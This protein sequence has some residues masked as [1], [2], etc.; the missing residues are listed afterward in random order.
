VAAG[1]TLTRRY[2]LSLTPAGAGN[3]AADTATAVPPLSGGPGDHGSEATHAL[4]IANSGGVGSRAAEGPGT[5]SWPG[6]PP[7]SPQAP[8]VTLVL[9]IARRAIWRTLCSTR[10]PRSAR[11]FMALSCTRTRKE[12]VLAPVESPCPCLI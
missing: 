12:G 6:P 7:S 3:E 4:T 2:A 9:L 8:E 11:S 10:P 5:A 1:R